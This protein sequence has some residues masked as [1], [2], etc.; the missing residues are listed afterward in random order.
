MKKSAVTL[1][2]KDLKN[3]IQNKSALIG[4][5]GL[6]YVGLPLALAFAEAGF[7]VV[8]VDLD[9]KRVN[10]INLGMSYLLDVKSER[11]GW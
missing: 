4:V 8:G 7:R 6:G 9:K 5:V 1:N 3:R 2:T 10:K 11:K